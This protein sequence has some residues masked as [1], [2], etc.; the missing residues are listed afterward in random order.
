MIDRL[1]IFEDRCEYTIAWDDDGN[2]GLLLGETVPKTYKEHTAATNA[3]RVVGDCEKRRDG[4]L[5]WE[6]ITGAK[7]ALRAARAAVKAVQANTP[8]PEWAIKA[9]A[10]G[11]KP[12]KGWKPG[13]SDHG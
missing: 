6:T 8:W 4:V 9:K 3:A 2:P 11:W 7:R 13:G 5:V 12:P 1:D 10:E